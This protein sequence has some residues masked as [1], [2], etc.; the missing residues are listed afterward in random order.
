MQLSSHLREHFSLQMEACHFQV[1]DAARIFSDNLHSTSVVKKIAHI[2]A[3]GTLSAGLLRAYGNMK[4]HIHKVKICMSVQGHVCV[5]VYGC[6]QNSPFLGQEKK[7]NNLDKKKSF[8]MCRSRYC[9]T[10]W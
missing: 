4:A 1:P 7:D 5:C 6:A 2:P 3:A 10:F 9:S 8:L